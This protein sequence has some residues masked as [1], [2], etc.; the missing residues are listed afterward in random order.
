MLVIDIINLFKYGTFNSK[1]ILFLRYGFPA[2]EIA[3]LE[4]CVTSITEDEIIFDN[5]SLAN[6]S[7]EIRNIIE[8]YLP[9]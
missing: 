4:K 1:H 2:E 9:K 8:W 3:T 5:E 6:C 7:Q